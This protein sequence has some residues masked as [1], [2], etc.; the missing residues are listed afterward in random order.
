MAQAWPRSSVCL[1]SPFPGLNQTELVYIRSDVNE[2]AQVP[3]LLGA[4]A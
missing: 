3:D 2:L 1:R 4:S